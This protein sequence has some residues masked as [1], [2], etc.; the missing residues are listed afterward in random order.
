MSAETPR[1]VVTRLAKAPT[2]PGLTAIA[3]ALLDLADAVR[4]AT[5][6]LDGFR[7]AWCPY[8]TAPW[9][10]TRKASRSCLSTTATADPSAV[11]ATA[12]RP[13]DER[14]RHLYPLHHRNLT[15]RGRRS[16]R[17]HLPKGAMT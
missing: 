14:R 11:D 17:P 9:V 6:K 3:H 16:P 5:G 12:D 15:G 10:A 13:H 1:E 7:T 4:E 2:D 8:S